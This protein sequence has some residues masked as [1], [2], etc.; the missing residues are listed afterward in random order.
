MSIEAG[1]LIS[2][3][4]DPLYW[5]LPERRTTVSLPDSK[6][7]WNHY[8]ENRNNVLGFAHSHPGDDQNIFPSWEDI[9][10]FSAIEIALGKKLQ[11][12]IINKKYTVLCNFKGPDKYN[13]DVKLV[14]EDKLFW[15][16]EL[17]KLSKYDPRRIELPMDVVIDKYNQ[18]Y[19]ALSIANEF[20]VSCGL[21]TDRL[22][23]QNIKLRTT[24]RQLYNYLCFDKIETEEF[25]SINDGLM[26]G[27]GNITVDNSLHLSQCKK[28]L[29]WLYQVRLL[30]KNLGITSSIIETKPTQSVY[31]DRVI[32]NNGSYILFTK[33]YAEIREQRDRWYP[34]GIKIVPKDIFLSPLCLAM[35][36]S[37]DGT[38]TDTG[39]ITFCTNG[40]DQQSID[41]LCKKMSQT[42]GVFP[43]VYESGDGPII[44]FNR[45]NDSLV[46][47]NAVEPYLEKCFNYKI[48]EIRAALPKGFYLRKFLDSQIREIRNLYKTGMSYTDLG[49]IFGVS[50]VT[51]SNIVNNKIYKNVEE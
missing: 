5:H 25:L 1:V 36:L 11:W 22:K 39:L 19:S 30:I 34:E 29:E 18:G 42:Y 37:G 2:L 20:G 43:A 38:C 3:S 15:I 41:L 9:T 28:R 12:W 32:K 14:D 23:E 45:R 31:K 4:G 40:F 48:K 8:W 10:T 35:W 51:I 6:E 24:Q 17:R 27:D 44:S 13:Y 21:V 33:A 46:I 47:K 50:K 16:K 49:V 26:L 7:L